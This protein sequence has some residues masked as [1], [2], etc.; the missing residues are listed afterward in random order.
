MSIRSDSPKKRRTQWIT[1]DTGCMCLPG[2]VQHKVNDVGMNFGS[3]GRASYPV[4]VGSF[5]CL[6]RSSLSGLQLWTHVVASLCAPLKN[7][8]R[9]PGARSLFQKAGLYTGH[10]QLCAASSLLI[11]FCRSE[12]GDD[13]D[14]KSNIRSL[15]VVLLRRKLLLGRLTGSWPHEIKI[16]SYEFCIRN[17][18][19]FD[20]RVGISLHVSLSKKKNPNSKGRCALVF[21][22]WLFSSSNCVLRNAGS[23]AGLQRGG[24][25]VQHRQ[26]CKTGQRGES[27]PGFAL[28]LRAARS[29]ISITWFESLF[30]RDLK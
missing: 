7:T 8:H 2:P 28:A 9:S 24:S 21:W 6:A 4:G 13:I 10:L 15:G 20:S 5:S 25:S 18:C 3:S 23:H 1:S 14:L 19:I 27:S 26:G 12:E 29:F 17:L 16:L 22:N 11:N 30:T